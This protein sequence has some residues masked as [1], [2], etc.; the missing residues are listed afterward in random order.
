MGLLQSHLDLKTVS[1]SLQGGGNS[2]SGS[3]GTGKR[4]RPSS[5]APSS[6]ASSLSG[7]R[8]KTGQLDTS[9][10]EFDYS[11]EKVKEKARQLA[12]SMPT[13]ENEIEVSSHELVAS[14]T[15]SLSGVGIVPLHY[16]LNGIQFLRNILMLKIRMRVSTKSTIRNMTSNETKPYDLSL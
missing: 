4:R 12:D 9:E 6:A 11:D 10:Y 14:L 5:V 2:G 8:K 13:F 16:Q 7:S 15:L 1:R 3:V